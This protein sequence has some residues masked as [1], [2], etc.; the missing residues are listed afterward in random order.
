MNTKDGQIIE[1]Q[2]EKKLNYIK[3]IEVFEKK[4]ELPDDPGV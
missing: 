4:I 2:M 3:A 1:D